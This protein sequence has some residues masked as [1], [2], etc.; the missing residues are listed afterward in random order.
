MKVEIDKVSADVAGKGMS[1]Y[2]TQTNLPLHNTIEHD[3]LL[4]NLSLSSET[5]PQNPDV[6]PVFLEIRWFS[7]WL[8]T[9]LTRGARQTKHQQQRNLAMCVKYGCSPAVHCM[10]HMKHEKSPGL[11]SKVPFTISHVYVFT[12]LRCKVRLKCVSS[13]RS[14]PRSHVCQSS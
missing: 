5:R 8:G 11:N 3:V 10:C 6:N 4:W 14:N 12:R 2:S 9:A 13:D 7:S 1:R